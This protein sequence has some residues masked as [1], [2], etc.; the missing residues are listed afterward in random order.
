MKKFLFLLAL[1]VAIGFNAQAKH[2]GKHCMGGG[3]VDTSVP[4]MS[5]ADVL[6]HKENS[7]VMMQGYI[8]R[9]LGNDQYNFTDG[10]DNIVLEI[11][12]KNWKGQTVSQKDMVNIGGEIEKEDGKTIVDVK[13]LNLVK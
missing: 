3:F 1:M 9:Q 5:V 8:T 4:V 11:D 6:K 2:E 13:S 10:K 12:D 7:Y